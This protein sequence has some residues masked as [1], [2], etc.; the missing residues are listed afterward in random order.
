MRTS[1][2]ISTEAVYIFHNM[3]RKLLT[4][5][6]PSTS[7]PFSKRANPRSAR[8]PSPSTRRTAPK[9]RR[10]WATRFPC[11][12]RVLEAIA[13]PFSNSPGFEADDVIGAIACRQPE[14]P[15]EV[16]IVSSDK[17]MLQLVNDRVSMLNP[18]KDDTWY[19]PAKVEE[20]MGVKPSQVADLLALKGDAIDNIPGAPGIGEK[21]AR[22]MIARF[23]S[24]EAALER[25]GEVERKMYRES[26][27]NNRERIL[28]SKRLATIDTSVP[29]EWISTTVKT[30]AARCRRAQAALQR[31]GVHEP[32]ARPARR[33]RQP[34]A[35]L[36]Q[37]RP[38][39]NWNNGSR[40]AP[41]AAPL[42]VTLDS[43]NSFLGLVIQGGRGQG[44]AAGSLALLSKS[45][46]E[47]P[48]HP[49]NVHDTKTSSIAFHSSG[50]AAAG[51][52]HDVMLY[53]FLLDAE[54]NGCSPEELAE[55]HLDRKLNAAAEQQ[56]E[57]TL[58]LFKSCARRSSAPALRRLRQ[59]SICRSP[60]CSR[61][62]RSRHPH[63]HRRAGRTLSSGSISEIEQIAAQVYAPRARPSTSTRRSNSARCCSRIWGCPRP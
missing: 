17:D 14:K 3:V 59:P 58:A 38:P 33:G 11:I 31:A 39:P 37:R 55:R 24:V 23:G 61:A 28:M 60:P 16:V 27:Q 46:L 19:D 36:P 45:A 32:A 13:S 57:T 56:A 20:F 44:S 48:G 7:P 51:F 41:P 25:A 53:A 4:A 42:A 40:L 21:G 63:R 30:Q 34:Q 43:T 8:K 29:V 18:M 22:D 54:P 6:S 1:T 62:W 10:T 5:I 49:E 26:L 35:R 12:R 15:L 2:G 47:S 9:C 52:E 50:V